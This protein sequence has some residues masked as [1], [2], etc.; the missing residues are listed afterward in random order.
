MFRLT[1]ARLLTLRLHP[2]R[3]VV[4]P[5]YPPIVLLR[6]RIG[7]GHRALIFRLEAYIS[8]TSRPELRPNPIVG[9]LPYALPN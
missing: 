8:A 6:R 7:L 1:A 4:S 5:S 9:T 2:R 3:S